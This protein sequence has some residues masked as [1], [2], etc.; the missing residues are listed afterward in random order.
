[1]SVGSEYLLEGEHNLNNALSLFS[2]YWI[3]NLLDK[4]PNCNPSWPDASRADTVGLMPVEQTFSWPGASRTD[5]V[6]LMPVA[7]TQ[8]A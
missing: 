6:G 5:T 2:L 1:M 4:I 7:Q 3:T 8:L